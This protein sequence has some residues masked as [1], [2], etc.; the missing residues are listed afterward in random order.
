M[1]LHNIIYLTKF[2]INSYIKFIE[3]SEKQQHGQ[4]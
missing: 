4:N 2:Q 3:L 1:I